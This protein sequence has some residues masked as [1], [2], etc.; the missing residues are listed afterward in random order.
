MALMKKLQPG[1][2]VD[3]NILNDAINQELSHYSLK[4]KDERKVRDALVQLR[5]YMATPE[6]K[7]FSV[8][9]VA[10]TFTVSGEGAEKFQGSPDKIKSG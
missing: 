6:G 5:D 8:D 9:P 4:S 2:T 3:Q 7:S 1:G 10:K